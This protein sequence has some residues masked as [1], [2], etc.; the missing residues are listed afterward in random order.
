M[1]TFIFTAGIILTVVLSSCGSLNHT[2]KVSEVDDRYYSLAD[3]NKERRQL[4][5]LQSTAPQDVEDRSGSA[6]RRNFN[7]NNEDFDGQDERFADYERFGG[8]APGG[9]NTVN[10]YYFDMDDYYDFQYA[11]RVRRFHRPMN[12]WGYF[13]PFYT[14]MFWYDPN[15][16][17]FGTSIYSTYAFWN[18]FSPWGWNTWGMGPGF[19][20]GWNSWTGFHMGFGTG[21]MFNSFYNPW[22]WNNF[23]RPWGFGSPWAFNPWGCY[24]PFLWGAPMG[25]FGMG[26]M[27]GF[28]N[29]FASAMF[30]NQMM[31]NQMHFNSFD[32]NTFVSGPNTG[33]LGGG[34]FGSVPLNQNFSQNIG[35]TT[36]SFRVNKFPTQAESAQTGAINLPQQGNNT[37]GLR[38]NQEVVREQASIQQQAGLGG[39]S[40]NQL[41]DRGEQ[42]RTPNNVIRGNQ[43]EAASVTTGLD[44]RQNLI[45]QGAS[46]S[47]VGIRNTEVQQQSPQPIRAN[48][49]RNPN[50]GADYSSAPVRAPQT[51]APAI[52]P[53]REPNIQ[54]GGGIR[55]NASYTPAP[56]PIRG[57]AIVPQVQQPGSQ[58]INRGN[59]YMNNR[60]FSRP[61][62]RPA[63]SIPQRDPGAVQR[64]QQSTPQR[65]N[66][67]PQRQIQQ[68]QRG[69]SPQFDNRSTIPQSRPSNFYNTPQRQTSPSYSPS[70]PS[71]QPSFNSPSP[72]RQ[73]SFNSP[74]PSRQPSYSAP[75]PS[76][77]P[78]M[79][80]PSPSRMSAPSSSPSRS[81]SP[82][83][84]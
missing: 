36:S 56:Q 46:P 44:S 11:S 57:N 12:R 15:P 4:R 31:T 32:S 47:G 55:S 43:V 66:S 7:E 17:F 73:P 5:K 62:Q 1:K 8:G 27:Q 76:R 48:V 30:M 9:G 25:G 45:N 19:N 22:A 3:A 37:N 28:N 70:A 64:P 16:L 42:G 72:S 39:K 40:L 26:Y 84:R 59:T 83:R 33:G 74:S 78:S 61:S 14:N 65:F 23:Y 58:D 81:A 71:R 77:S 41:G 53:G 49:N 2:A 69:T 54:P 29:G 24:N 38:G 75:S 10:N 63:V 79:S 18:P 82:S 60:D 13:D 51:A 6:M 50:I 80:S 21:S 34:S 35:T 67:Q 52:M 68:P 20:I